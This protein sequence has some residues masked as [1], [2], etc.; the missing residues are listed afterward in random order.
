MVA[1]SVRTRVVSWKLAALR[2]LSVSKLAFLDDVALEDDDVAANRDEVLLFLFG[3]RVFDNNGALAANARSEIDDA[4]DLGDFCGVLGTAGF[5]QLG[6]T[7]Q[8]AGDVLGF[9]GL[10]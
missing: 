9:R 6:H 3:L 5:E 1:A 10:A 7:G 4:V 2:K 8:T